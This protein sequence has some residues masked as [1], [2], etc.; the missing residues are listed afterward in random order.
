MSLMR[1]WTYSSGLSAINAVE[2]SICRFPHVD[3]CPLCLRIRSN[4]KRQWQGKTWGSMSK[5]SYSAVAKTNV[6]EQCRLLDVLE[7]RKQQLQSNGIVDVKEVQIIKVNERMKRIQVLKPAEDETGKTI[8]EADQ[9]PKA[10]GVRWIKKLRR[11]KWIKPLKS[12]FTMNQA[13]AVKKAKEKEKETGKFL[14][15]FKK[16]VNTK[17][18]QSDKDVDHVDEA[19]LEIRCY[20]ETCGFI[21]NAER[22]HQYLSFYHS[23]LTRRSKLS[24]NSYNIVMRI[25]AKNSSMDKIQRVFEMIDEAGLTP[26]VS[27]YRA[28]L[29]CLGRIPH[30]SSDFVI[31]CVEKMKSSGILLDDLLS[32]CLFIKDEREM[33]LK[34]VKSLQ[35]GYKPHVSN[36]KPICTI[37]LLK[38]F[39]CE[40]QL[41]LEKA[42]SVT[43]NSVEGL[44]PI[45]TEVTSM[46]GL[47][48]AQRTRWNRALLMALQNSKYNMSRLDQSDNKMS[49]KHC[50]YPYLCVLE[51]QEYVN[52]MLQH[53]DKMP[54]NGESVMA[55]T[56]EMGNSVYNLYISRQKINDQIVPKLRK[57]YSSYVKLLA[58]DT[59]ING[60][61]PR[62]Y[63]KDLEK[64]FRSGP[65]LK[66]DTTPW[67]KVLKVQVGNFLLDL[68][69]H[70]LKIYSNI[71]NRAYEKKLIPVLYHLYTF[72]GFRKI[73]F[74]KQHPILAHIQR[75]GKETKLTFNTCMMPMLCCP[76]PWTSQK[77]GGYLLIPSQLMRAHGRVFQHMVLLDNAREENLHGVLDSLNKLGTC[78]WKVNKPIL[79]IIISIFNDK[80]N[81]KLSIPPPLTEAPKILQVDQ[82]HT[83]EEKSAIKK[84]SMKIKKIQAE[85]LSQRMD[86]LYKLSI[87]NH[88]RDEI[89]WF[90]HNMDFRGRTYPIAPHFNHLGSDVTRSMLLFAEGRPL[91][92]NG[93]NWLKIH[94]VNLTGLMKTRSL[95]ER[96]EFADTIMDE[97]LDS[98]DH[99]LDGR[100]WWMNVD[101]PWQTLA[102]CME[103]AKVVR[104]PDP[105]K[106]I[107]HFPIQQDGSCNGL[108]HYAALGRDVI[109]AASV[110]L[111]HSELPQ[112]VYIGVA[113]KV[114]EQR[115]RDA[116]GGLKI[117]KVLEGFITRKVVKQ[118]VMTVVYG[119]TRYGGRL[120]FEKRL[121]ELDD[122]PQESVWDASHY[123]TAKVFESLRQMF[124]GTR[125]IQEWLTQSASLIAKS[126]RS[127][128]WV[129]P[130][131]LPIIQPYHRKKMKVVPTEGLQNLHINEADDEKP[132]PNSMKQK[133][134]FPPNFIHSL[135]STH[136]ML[137]ALHCHRAGLTFVSVHDCYW[138]H[139]TNVD[140]MNQVCREQFVALHSQPILK[141]LSLF[142]LHKYITKPQP[143]SSIKTLKQI[144]M[145][146][147]LSTVPKPGQFDLEEVKRSLYFF[148]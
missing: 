139:A 59:E 34:A 105:T 112:D 141:E 104:S 71:L 53:L 88:V 111:K 98:A 60:M 35:P 14:E 46:R 91:G 4:G 36:T 90:P 122:F 92:S 127:V 136:M 44:S 6:S 22:A 7:A 85:M 146:R 108:Q 43:I 57:I 52:I 66:N 64:E 26:N 68:M 95:R 87:A 8:T 128:E 84:D 48:A 39:Y 65:S 89:F 25:W 54:P 16:A 24:I 77:S 123:L 80:G 145:A 17:T 15:M 106:F 131:G 120:Q 5:R 103:I 9:P 74:I 27:S 119:V 94:L 41:I 73:G 11:E 1:L 130:L 113:K 28:V 102:C 21:N 37:P 116:A 76:T 143:G 23:K 99:P 121:K 2:R 30:Y 45:S 42:A 31:R 133:N 47:L 148:S 40:R 81:R 109:G 142:L 56:E 140:I 75:V 32:Q 110:N 20:L 78:P 144:E 135:D 58:K 13:D 134:A 100:K 107:S 49:W 82:S 114:E 93:F 97:I 132:K 12:T 138:T 117:A 63:W 69:V 124:T 115:A 86:A 38:K 67:T 101:E 147:V 61:L 33:V 72:R 70:H 137:T 129:T 10:F 96:L 126:G 62:E 83:T 29:E 18:H 118:T 3:Y 125:E 50:F 55:L 51:D 79:D 19:N